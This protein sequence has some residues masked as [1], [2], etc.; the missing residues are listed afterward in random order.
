MGM[1]VRGPTSL[2]VAGLLAVC[3]GASSGAVAGAGRLTAP[4]IVVS[5]TRRANVLNLFELNSRGGLHRLLASKRAQLEPALSPDGTK[6]AYVETQSVKCGA[7]PW[8]IWIMNSDGTGRHG[9]TYPQPYQRNPTLYDQT[10]SW[11]PD[12]KE[13]VFSRSTGLDNY[14]LLIIPATGGVPRETFVGGVSPAWGP[15][16]I[17]YIQLETNRPGPVELW[18][19]KPDGSDPELIDTAFVVTPTWS[20]SG[21]LAYLDAPPDAPPTLIVVRGGEAHRYLLPFV[22]AASVTWSPDGEHLAIVAK[23]SPTASYDLY[24]I[25]ADGKGLRRLTSGAGASDVSWGK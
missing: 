22:G 13:I 17:A 14:D 25:G 5:A 4:G 9:L 3:V 16:R 1:R 6:I 2:L 20:R 12:G 15:K 21:N 23:A 24:T 7:C 18:T 8:T 10:P 11:S 19:M